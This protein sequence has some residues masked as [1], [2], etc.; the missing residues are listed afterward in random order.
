MG[1]PFGDRGIEVLR[2]SGI[3]KYRLSVK[4]CCSPAFGWACLCVE[5][6]NAKTRVRTRVACQ[7]SYKRRFVQKPRKSRKPTERTRR[8]FFAKI[9][10]EKY[11]CKTSWATG[12]VTAARAFT[13]SA[14]TTKTISGFSY[15]AKTD[16]QTL[17]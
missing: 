4:V 9:Y 11:H 3:E 14:V 2:I 12:R 17:N 13:F 6:T 15:G 7:L 10:L 5:D 1:S 8:S 16:D